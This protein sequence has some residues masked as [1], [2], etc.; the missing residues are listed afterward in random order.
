MGCLSLARE[1]DTLYQGA[2][3]HSAAYF[4]LLFIPATLLSMCLRLS[5]RHNG[6]MYTLGLT[7]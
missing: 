7:Y 1:N 5:S 3:R 6:K 2:K 4:L